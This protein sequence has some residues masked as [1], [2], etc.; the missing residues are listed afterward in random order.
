MSRN[1]NWMVREEPEKM[2]DVGILTSLPSAWS[3][4]VVS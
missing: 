4:Q 3:F 2:F 1:D